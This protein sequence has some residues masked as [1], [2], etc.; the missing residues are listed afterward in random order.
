[1]IT[2]IEGI[3]V[4]AKNRVKSSIEILDPVTIVLSI[5]AV[6]GAVSAV[7]AVLAFREYQGQ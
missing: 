3:R 7:L 1:M 6:V 5:A 2:E 4:W